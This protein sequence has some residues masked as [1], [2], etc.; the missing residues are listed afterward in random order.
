MST[1][2]TIDPVTRIEGHAKI[3]IHLD[4]GGEVTDARFHVNEFRGFEKFCEGRLLWEMPGI[5]SRI[6]GICPAS[7]LVT[8]A[9]AGDEIFAVSIPETAEKLRRL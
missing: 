5:T 9:K 6:C 8:S 1:I 7:H 2:L 3:T 4:G